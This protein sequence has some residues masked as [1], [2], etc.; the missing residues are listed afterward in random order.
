MPKWLFVNAKMII[1]IEKAMPI[2]ANEKY[3]FA[4]L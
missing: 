3:A 4:T 2:I 1:K